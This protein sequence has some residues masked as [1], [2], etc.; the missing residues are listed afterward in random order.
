MD[1]NQKLYFHLKKNTCKINQPKNIKLKIAGH[2]LIIGVNWF[3]DIETKGCKMRPWFALL[4]IGVH[5]FVLVLENI[6]CFLQVIDEKGYGVRQVKGLWSET[7][8]NL[9][10]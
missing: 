7:G 1:V 5:C 2:K 4:C 8:E 9:H 3:R 10:C 6:F